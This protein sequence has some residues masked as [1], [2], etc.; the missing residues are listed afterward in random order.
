MKNYIKAF[1]NEKLKGNMKSNIEDTGD[2]YPDN[3]DRVNA[4]QKLK[5]FISEGNLTKIKGSQLDPHEILHNLKKSK[6][7]LE[8]EILHA[9]WEQKKKDIVSQVKK[10]MLESGKDPNTF[11]GLVK[12]S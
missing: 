11:D 4:R 2:R 10:M 5:S 9:Q 1:L 3:E 12:F 8:K 7:N 6:S